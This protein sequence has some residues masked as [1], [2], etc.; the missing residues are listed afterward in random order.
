MAQEQNFK[1]HVRLDPLFH[2]FLTPAA[3]A[4]V[5]AAV[6]NLIRNPGW[7]AGA[8]LLA[9]LWAFIATFKIRL[10]ALRVQDR[11][12]WLEERLR[13]KEL[14]APPLRARAAELTYDQCI[15]L[16]FASDEEVPSLVEQALAG[17]WNRKQIKQAVKTWRPD[18]LRV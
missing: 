13:L 18:H 14:L 12:I 11:L 10:Y 3:L 9:A 15:G 1:N 6:V 16:R 5:I 4:L 2:L 7:P 8:H 17:Q